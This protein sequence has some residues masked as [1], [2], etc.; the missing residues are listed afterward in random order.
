MSKHTPREVRT[1]SIPVVADDA[2]SVSLNQLAEERDR[3]RE[4]NKELL[5]AL[6][7]FANLD[8][9]D[10]GRMS[11]NAWRDDFIRSAPEYIG[12]CKEARSVIAKANS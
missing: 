8:A 9:A 6:E 10:L 7:K 3:L 11:I 4:V 12:Y 5:A 1:V 2:I